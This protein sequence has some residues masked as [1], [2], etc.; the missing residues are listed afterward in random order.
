MNVLVEMGNLN[1]NAVGAEGPAVTY[2][3]VPDSY[4][5]EVAK[6]AETLANDVAAHVGR[7]S[8]GVTRLPDQEALLAVVAAWNAESGGSPE[9]VWSDNKDFAVLLGRFYDCQVGRPDDIEATH[10]TNAGPPSQGATR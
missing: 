8:N 6:S 5:Y 2:I 4:T 1:P 7:A 9:W 3:G 10:H